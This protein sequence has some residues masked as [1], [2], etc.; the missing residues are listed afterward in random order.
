MASADRCGA[1]EL[2]YLSRCVVSAD[3]RVEFTQNDVEIIMTHSH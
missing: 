1:K 3:Q 2:S